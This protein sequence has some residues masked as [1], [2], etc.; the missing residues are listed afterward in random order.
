MTEGDCTTAEPIRCEECGNVI[1]VPCAFL[2]ISGRG[3]YHIECA[4]RHG[5]AVVDGEEQS[6]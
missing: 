5:Y 2:F 6:R 3:S 1:V 4:G